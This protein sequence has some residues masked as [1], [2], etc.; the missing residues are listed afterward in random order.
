MLKVSNKSSIEGLFIS[1]SVGYRVNETLSVGAGVSAIYT[2]FNEKFAINNAGSED[3]ELHM[4]DL[5][6]WIGQEFFGLT[7]QATDKLMV[8]L[9]YRTKS[10]VDLDGDLKITGAEGPP[11]INQ[12]ASSLDSVEIGFDLSQT[13]EVGGSTM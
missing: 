8:G 4:D 3:G 2:I 11:P 13:I 10:D 5:T 7:L 1:H 12:L 6:D 9:F